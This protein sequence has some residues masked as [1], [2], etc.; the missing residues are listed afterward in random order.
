[1]RN[2]LLV[3]AI[4]CFF[5][6]CEG[7][8]INGIITP[9]DPINPTDSSVV[10]VRDSSEVV[11]KASIV[12][13]S[14]KD[15]DESFE[16]NDEVAILAGDPINSGLVK[17]VVKNGSLS[18]DSPICWNNEASQ[19]TDFYLAYPYSLSVA[20]LGFSDE[21]QFS[22]SVNADQSTKERYRESDLMMSY[23]SGTPADK[24]I[25]FE[26]KHLL[27]Q[28]CIT[29]ENKTN[30]KIESI[31]VAGL[32]TGV[33]VDSELS[34]KVEGAQKETKALDVS[35]NSAPAWMLIIPP[36]TAKPE[37]LISISGGEQISYPLPQ[38]VVLQSGFS[39][40]VSATLEEDKTVCDIKVEIDDWISGPAFDIN[41]QW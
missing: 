19:K 25:H 24:E 39:S 31:S 17:Y 2:I 36:Q 6:S 16:E 38:E 13:F 20:A 37:L 7:T 21:K 5:V 34:V 32:Y 29:I 26:V 30:K 27:S 23:S 41:L 10:V 33:L 18:S 1:M 12:K 22:F 11:F 35:Q 15:S 4:L 3:S 40:I 9:P 8:D 28:M 14:S